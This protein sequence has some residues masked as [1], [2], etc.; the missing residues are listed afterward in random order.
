[1]IDP[2]DDAATEA[3]FAT[4]VARHP[5]GPDDTYAY[6]PHPEQVVELWAGADDAPV[7]VSIHGG[8]FMAEFDRALHHPI[9][10]RLSD[11]GFEVH[12]I[13]YRRTGSADDPADT[14]AD[15]RAA[16]RGVIARTGCRV[17]VFGHS[18]GGY[19]AEQV[20]DEDG[21]ALVVPLAPITDLERW[22]ADADPDHCLEAWLG[23]RDHAAACRDLTTDPRRPVGS[24][25]VLLH[26]SADAVVPLEHSEWYAAAAGI[27][28]RVLPGEGHFAFLDP[29]EPAFAELVSLLQP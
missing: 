17:A 6:G 24:T 3:W 1:M 13:E 12:N 19:L 18:A 4:V 27:E 15:A 8:A 26:G 11:L 5:A 21:V 14:V 16:V 7:V 23:E 22:G 10:G 29:D 28:L 2:A 25:R 9:C 20:A